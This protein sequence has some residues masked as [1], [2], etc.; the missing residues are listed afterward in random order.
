MK[1]W[2][3]I[4]N[5]AMLGTGKP[6]PARSDMPVA[7]AEAAAVIDATDTGKE[8]GFLQRACMV[9]NYRQCGFHPIKRPEATITKAE[10]ETKPG[11]SAVA[12]GILASVLEEDN[13]WLLKYWLHRCAATEQLM[14]PDVLPALM[15][16]AQKAADLQSLVVACAGNRGK[17]LAGF[18]PD[19]SYFTP[20]SDEEMWQNGKPEE[21][22]SV[23]RKI[24][25]EEPARALEMV[26]QT[27]AQENAAGKVELLKILATNSS[28]A[29]LPWLESLGG[30]K[31]QKVKDE[32]IALL[33]SIPGSSVISK[34]EAVL[35]EAVAL[36][37]EKALLGLM[38]KTSIQLKLPANVDEGIFKSG[39]EKLISNK[40]TLTDENYVIYQLVSYVPPVFWEQH[41]AAPPEQVVEYFDNYAK[42]LLPALVLAVIRFNADNWIPHLLDEPQLYPEF[43]NKLDPARQQQYLLRFFAGDPASV[44]NHALGTANEWGMDFTLTALQ[45][46]VNNPYQYNRNFYKDNIRVINSGVLAKLD[47]INPK[48]TSLSVIWGENCDY[49]SKLLNLKQKV[50]EVFNAKQ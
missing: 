36:K 47:A 44:I 14:P 42:T 48:D 31:G 15:D 19:W 12:A 41:F 9:Y 4:I 23:L 38:N 40:S 30:E 7:I 18:N 39:I 1:A 2:D 20:E 46:T 45:Y 13:A 34:Y 33:K 25:K 37:K 3:D 6:M 28:P 11:C 21:R 49:L 5:T 27:W 32:T 26:N 50:R 17:W 8:D 10:A 35:R 29:D 22:L 24:R 16:K 43:L